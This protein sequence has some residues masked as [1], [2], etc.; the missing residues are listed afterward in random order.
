MARSSPAK[1]IHSCGSSSGSI[2]MAVVEQSSLVNNRSRKRG[3]K[4][5]AP[6]EIRA[7]HNHEIERLANIK[8][9]SLKSAGITPLRRNV[10]RNNDEKVQ[11]AVR[12]GL[13]AS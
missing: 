13:A 12:P 11:V 10:I 5:T 9:A 1:E 4:V 7:A 8:P 3:R 2:D 6:F